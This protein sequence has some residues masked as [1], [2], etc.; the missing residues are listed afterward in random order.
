MSTAAD[1]KALGNASLQAGDF[2]QA[3]IHYTSA[4]DLDGTNHV[5]YSNRSA[6]YLSSNQN[7]KALDDGESCIG[8]NPTWAKGYTRKA[9][10]LWKLSR[11]NDAEACYNSGIEK[12]GEDKSLVE[13]LKK[14]IDSKNAPPVSSNPMANIFG[15]G[16]INKIGGDPKL[17]EYLSDPTFMS[18]IEMLQKNPNSLQMMMGDPRIMEV[19]QLALGGNVSF[20]NPDEAPEA[21][22]K[23]P[24]KK[25]EPEPEPEEDTSWMNEEE[26]KKHEDKKLAKKKK[27]EGNEKYKVKAFDEAIA[28]YDEAIA[29]DP[30]NMTYITNKSAVFFARKEW[31]LC[32]SICEEGLKVGKENYAPFEDR[33]KALTRMGKCYHKKK[34]LGKAIEMYKASQLE[35]FQKD[36]ERLL[37]NLELEKRKKDVAEYQDPEK[38]EEAKQR[39]NDAFRAQ[40]WPDAIKNYEEAVKRAPTNPAIRN[41]LAAVLCKVMDFNGAKMHV[42]KALELDEKYVKAYARKGDIHVL[43]KENHKALEAYRAGLAIEANNKAC[44]EGATKV[45]QLI[46]A[47]AANMSEEEKQER[48]AHGMADPEIQAILQDP[49]IR[50]VL[51]D[52]QENPNAAQQAMKD[53]SVSTKIEKLIAAGVLQVGR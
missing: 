44:M 23:D 14:L 18:K 49:I 26:L 28:F 37:K 6:A 34:E 25:K 51:Q 43:M 24:E 16:L 17:K 9:A 33:A 38:A 45:T 13:G 52:F 40:N 22:K 3:I 4:I 7:Q 31:D 29:L 42:D 50:Q 46:N 48:A 19:L 39:G 5:F 1:F 8:L 32:I 10:A 53:V 11:L 41:N 36:T 27:E 21:P 12:C 15:P 47:G 35:A 30:T 2:P 20:G